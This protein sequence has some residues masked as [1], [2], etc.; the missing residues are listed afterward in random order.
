[1]GRRHVQV[2]L[3]APSAKSMN[4]G[5]C[6]VLITTNDVFAWFGE[7]ANIVEVNKTREL[8]SW[9]YKKHELSYHGSLGESVANT[10]NGYISVHENANATEDD[11]DGEID[12]ESYVV[13]SDNVN[14]SYSA[15]L[16]FWKTLGYDSPQKVHR[17]YF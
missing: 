1:M 17:K 2:R 9:I 13:I 10:T 7:S 4:S 3:V 15:T 14:R 12:N 5:D 6:F 8:A 11:D 16:K